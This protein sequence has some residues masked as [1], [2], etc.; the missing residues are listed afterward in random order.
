MTQRL[1]D[2]WKDYY[3]NLAQLYY[4]YHYINNNIF[5]YNDKIGI[6]FYHS[7]QSHI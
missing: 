6:F 1:T 4:C 7:I 3:Q 2:G 5:L